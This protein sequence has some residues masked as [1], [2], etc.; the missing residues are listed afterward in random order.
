MGSGAIAHAEQAE[1]EIVTTPEEL[2]G[3]SIVKAIACSEV[4]P[5]RIV[6]R[7]QM[8]YFAILLD[9]NNRKTVARLWFNQKKQKYIGTFDENKVETKHPIT[10]PDGIYEFTDTIRATVRHLRDGQSA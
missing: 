7:D 2:D 6:S 8:S 3:F 4:K 10:S 1:S 9:D 5:Q